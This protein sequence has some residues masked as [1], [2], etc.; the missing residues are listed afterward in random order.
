MLKARL[1]LTVALAALVMTTF[2]ATTGAQAAK[3]TKEERRAEAEQIMGTMRAYIRV[4]FARSGQVSA[5]LVGKVADGA[6]G[7]EESELKGTYYTIEDKVYDAGNNQ[8]AVIAL[9][10]DKADGVGLLT[11]K[12][13]SGEGTTTW[14]DDLE[15]L[16]KANK[17][18]TFPDKKDEAK[19]EAKEAAGDANDPWITFR[20]EG[21]SWTYKMTGDMKMTTT[22]KNVTENGC[23]METQMFMADGTALGPSNTT[24]IKFELGNVPKGE[25]PA[26]PKSKEEKVKVTAGEY[27]CISYDDGKTWIMKKYPSII[28]KSEHMELVEFKE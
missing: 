17:N 5:T 19:G 24:T 14:Y 2:T 1:G 21:R 13:A 10:K 28:V 20:K 4:S 8:C 15:A 3:N 18:I 16:K 26:L 11:F 25:Q 23:D 9:P 27:D 7:A 12:L 22:I 6:A